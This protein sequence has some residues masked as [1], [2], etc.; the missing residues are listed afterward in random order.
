M[1]QGFKYI[2][3]EIL[4]YRQFKIYQYTV[5]KNG[6]IIEILDF[7]LETLSETF[8]DMMNSTKRIFES[9]FKKKF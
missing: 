4:D 6:M 9:L 1:H 8:E 2:L 3:L 7:E 5:F